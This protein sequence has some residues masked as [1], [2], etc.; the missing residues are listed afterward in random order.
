MSKKNRKSLFTWCIRALAVS[1]LPTLVLVS[2]ADD[3]SDKATP[4]ANVAPFVD[5]SDPAS[6]ETIVST[7]N[8]SVTF[9]EAVKGL[10]YNASDGTCSGTVQLADANKC[11]GID[12]STS[13]NLTWTFN[14]K[15][16]L[17]LGSDITLT[18]SKDITDLEGLGM[19][20]NTV[21]SFTVQDALTTVAV[22]L[23]KDLLAAGL[24]AG[25]ATSLSTAARTAASSV[26]NDLASVIPAAVGGA[27][28]AVDGLSLSAADESKAYETLVESAIAQIN[29]VES[30]SD[31]NARSAEFSIS[32]LNSIIR[33]FD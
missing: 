30:L 15:S 32:E 12:V 10:V 4:V 23:E 20:T 27:I 13:D 3:S 21:L 22:N 24:T 25:T 11:Y 6:G 28:Q 29:G 31:S 8:F 1:L 17:P 14:P 16:N 26:D 18:I 5:G 33:S 9:S 2:C 7:S 19:T